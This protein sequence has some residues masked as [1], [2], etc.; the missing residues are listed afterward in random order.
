MHAG[1]LLVVLVAVAGC[2][3]GATGPAGASSACVGGRGDPIA[4]LLAR[5]GGDAGTFRLVF[6]GR[7]TKVH[8]AVRDDG[9]GVVTPVEVGV[10]EVLRGRAGAV[11]RTRSPG[12]TLPDGSGVGVEDGVAWRRGRRY[13]VVARVEPDG[14]FLAGGCGLT[15]ALSLGQAAALAARYHARFRPVPDSAVQPDDAAGVDWRGRITAGVAVLV[16]LAAGAVVVGGRARGRRNAA[17]WS[18]GSSSR[19]PRGRR[20]SRPGRWCDGRAARPR[21]GGG[22]ASRSRPIVPGTSR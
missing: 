14:G 7:V 15:R 20:S 22:P 2:L 18:A 1:R 5:R 4:P 8:R 12:G 3:A 21:R 13:V 19:P 9:W 10:E 11:L 17:T 16:V 6:V